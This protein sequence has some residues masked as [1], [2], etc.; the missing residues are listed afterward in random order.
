V[1]LTT[2]WHSPTLGVVTHPHFQQDI[3]ADQLEH[4][5]KTNDAIGKI[6]NAIG[7]ISAVQYRQQAQKYRDE[8]AGLR[9]ELAQIENQSQFS[10]N[11]PAP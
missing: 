1:A 2:Q 11:V 9:D 4:T 7:S 3:L 5:G 8:A 6:F 10:A